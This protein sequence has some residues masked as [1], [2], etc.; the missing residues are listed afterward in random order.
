[1]ELALGLAPVGARRDA[2]VGPSLAMGFRSVCRLANAAAFGALR[3]LLVAA[4]AIAIRRARAMGGD[5]PPAWITRGG[6]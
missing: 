6:L 5:H 2:M 3:R 1:M 4:L